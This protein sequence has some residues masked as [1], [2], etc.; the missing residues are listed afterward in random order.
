MFTQ[1]TQSL[2]MSDR[3][4][5]MVLTKI[6]R[7][8]PFLLLPFLFFVSSIGYG[9]VANFPTVSSSNCTGVSFS[10]KVTI[11][12][13]SIVK[14]DCNCSF[15]YTINF[16]YENVFSGPTP[17][18]WNPTFDNYFV[19]IN[20]S[21][22]NVSLGTVSISGVSLTNP[23]SG[24]AATYNAAYPAGL[25]SLGLP[26]VSATYTDPSVLAIF[27]LSSVE[28]SFSDWECFNGIGPSTAPLPVTLSS[29]TVNSTEGKTVELNWTTSDETDN[30]GFDVEHSLDARNW[31]K[32]GFVQTKAA[33]G[34]ST[35]DIQYTFL[36]SSPHL[37]QN[38]YRLIQHDFDGKSTPSIIR[39]INV[40][41]SESVVI[42]PNPVVDIVRISVKDE[43]GKVSE[44]ALT[45]ASGK[46][47]KKL[48]SQATEVNLSGL[49]SGV[50]YLYLVTEKGTV[51]KK[52][53]KN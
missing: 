4:F 35:T 53:F 25:T 5:G 33:E 1:Y 42:Y 22:P 7:R 18:P 6:T 11:N 44:M 17:S 52:L 48:S 36:H 43:V 39:S 34:N 29:F 38:Y 8:L 23:S 10:S 20:S 16:S 50:Y 27:G 49:S 37:G 12:S 31:S 45:D 47:I 15:T 46:D 40:F 41:S 51:Y 2:G 14:N 30:S 24:S 13:V 19:K 28:R 21:N 3:T 9:Q 26:N 32:L